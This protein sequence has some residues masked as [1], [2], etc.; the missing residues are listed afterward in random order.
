[1]RELTEVRLDANA[2]TLAESTLDGDP[3]TSRV[4]GD[5]IV[6]TFPYAVRAGRVVTLGFNYAGTPARGLVWEE[7]GFY[8]SH[9]SCDWMFCAL[10]RPG[11]AFTL[12]VDWT[13]V[14]GLQVLSPET[15]HAYPAHVQGFAVGRWT[16]A[17]E[18]AGETTFVFASMHASEPDM[19]AMFAET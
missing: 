19:R 8:T 6:F 5:G 15:A 4:D 11:D 3:M 12:H 17:R 1:E 7:N 13:G 14:E 16:E 2:L 9:F 10:N 18:H